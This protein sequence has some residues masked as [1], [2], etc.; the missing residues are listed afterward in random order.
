[1]HVLCLL[2]ESAVKMMYDFRA[3]YHGAGELG[4][5]ELG[6]GGYGL[7]KNPDDTILNSI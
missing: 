6:A 4:A 2:L 5:G 1:M 3:G 7:G